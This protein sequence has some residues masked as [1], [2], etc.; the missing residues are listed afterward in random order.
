MPR[1]VMYIGIKLLNQ[2]DRI[3]VTQFMTSDYC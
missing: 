3:P 2:T 1:T